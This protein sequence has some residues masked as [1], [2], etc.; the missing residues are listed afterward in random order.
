MK[1][2]TQISFAI[3]PFLYFCSSEISKDIHEN[4]STKKSNKPIDTI[5]KSIDEKFKATVSSDID[6]IKNSNNSDDIIC[7]VG[8]HSPI[9]LEKE[10]PNTHFIF[11]S[12]S[13]ELVE[14]VY[15]ENGDIL[16]I[17]HSGCEYYVL[18]FRFETKR[19]SSDVND[20]Q[21]WSNVVVTLMREIIQ[22]IDPPIEINSG[23]DTLEKYLKEKRKIEFGEQIDYGI[24]EIRNFLSIDNVQ[25]I[26]SSKYAIEITFAYGPL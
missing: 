1:F 5:T 11:N 10:F 26:D 15:L 24:D 20:I 19:F 3:I 21:Y 14:H 9:V 23:I 2:F 17:Y 4:D 8:K 12:D 16:K 25:K 13:S 18:K 7:I 6:S 22:K